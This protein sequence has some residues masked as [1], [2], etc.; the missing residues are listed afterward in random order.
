MKETSKPQIPETFVYSHE[1]YAGSIG[2]VWKHAILRFIVTTLE[3]S[4]SP[5][6]RF[7]DAHCGSGRYQLSPGGKWQY[8]LAKLLARGEPFGLESESL[9]SAI[10]SRQSPTTYPGSW[11]QVAQISDVISTI[12]GIDHSQD[13]LERATFTAKEAPTKTISF[14]QADSFSYL[15]QACLR[16]SLVLVDPAYCLK[17]GKGCDW[18][19]L[20]EQPLLSKL[21]EAYTLIWYPVYGPQKPDYLTQKYQA[22]GWEIRWPLR[23]KSAFVPSGCGVLISASLNRQ[24]EGLEKYLA[25]LAGYLDSEFVIRKPSHPG[26]NTPKNNIIVN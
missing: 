5:A 16:Q 15:N 21:R 22:K 8:G 2:D 11:L 14:V 26:Q 23:R 25:S 12:I 17:D 6:T 20:C 7:I 24:I 19:K 10:S 13:V 1:P 9:D 4:S 3:S 18:E